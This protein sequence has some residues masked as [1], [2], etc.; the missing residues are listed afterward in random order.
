MLDSGEISVEDSTRDY[1]V[2]AG[3]PADLQLDS[4]T[5]PLCL[6]CGVNVMKRLVFIYRSH[7]LGEC[8]VSSALRIFTGLLLFCR[9]RGSLRR[10]QGALLVRLGVQDSDEPCKPRWVSSCN[11]SIVSLLDFEYFLFQAF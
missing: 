10:P 4:K 1:P 5:T 9:T 7:M 8:L 6:N 2:V 3:L 11:L